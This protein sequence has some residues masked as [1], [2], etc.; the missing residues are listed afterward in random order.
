M[1]GDFIVISLEGFKKALEVTAPKGWTVEVREAG[2]VV[3]QTPAKE[4]AGKYDLKVGEA[5]IAVE[6]VPIVK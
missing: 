2:R 6:L 1:P 4:K 3:V 5:E